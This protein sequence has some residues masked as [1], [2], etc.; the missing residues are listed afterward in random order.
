VAHVYVP[1][2][3]R[4]WSKESASLVIFVISAIF[5]EETPFSRPGAA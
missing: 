4:K 1:L 3:N 2:T 5:H